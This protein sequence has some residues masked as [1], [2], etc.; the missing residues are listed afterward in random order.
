MRNFFHSLALALFLTCAG[1]G[2]ADNG[3]T[4]G[5]TGVMASAD[6]RLTRNIDTIWKKFPGRAGI[7]IY[8]PFSDDVIGK[9]HAERFPQQSV[10]KLWVALT[11]LDMEA[12][13]KLS[14]D[15]RIRISRDDVVV[16][17]QPLKRYLDKKDMFEMSVR[18]LLAYSINAS[19]NL[20]NNVLL[21][22]AGGPQAVNQM[23]ERRN[24]ESIR[25]GP[26]EVLSQGQ[27]VQGA[28]G[29]HPD[30]KKEGRV[31][32]LSQFTA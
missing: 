9:R 5:A 13:G 20:A 23:L 11:I 4:K 14:L 15:K 12:A 32:G 18:E 28:T 30:G 31:N 24:I 25:F 6:A 10:S 22:V 8:T 21:R 3:N 2:R 1:A 27:C 29:A 16:F 17:S 26:G 7:A 19:D